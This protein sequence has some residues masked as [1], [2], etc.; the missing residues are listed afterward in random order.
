MRES[1]FET[2]T[3]S[4]CEYIDI[5]FILRLKKQNLARETKSQNV[6]FRARS[7]SGEFSQRAHLIAPRNNCFTFVFKVSKNQK[8]AR[9]TRLKKKQKYALDTRLYTSAPC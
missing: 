4:S 5:G 2:A 9:Y 8:I 3:L 7:S 1:L 6:F